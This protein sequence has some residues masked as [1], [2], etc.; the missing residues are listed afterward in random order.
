M[1]HN[2]I[3]PQILSQ[4]HYCSPLVSSELLS[5]LPINY[6]I[7]NTG[8]IFDFQPVKTASLIWSLKPLT[9]CSFQ[10][11]RLTCT[12]LVPL[13]PWWHPFSVSMPQPSSIRT[14]AHA[15]CH[16]LKVGSFLLYKYHLQNFT[17]IYDCWYFSL[18]LEWKDM[19]EG[20]AIFFSNQTQPH[21]WYKIG[22]C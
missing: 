19:K 12:L 10:S 16:I 3:L 14:F 20:I 1:C 11:P 13:Q 18:P 5:L 15:L 6:H 2:C 4:L 9:V 17:F 22:T 8:V 7:P 21:T